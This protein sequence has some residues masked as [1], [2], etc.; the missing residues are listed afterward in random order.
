MTQR[1]LKALCR[2]RDD[3]DIKMINKPPGHLV[4]FLLG[5]PMPEEE[6]GPPSIK[7]LL[8]GS[9]G[10]KEEARTEGCSCIYGNPCTDQYICKNWNDRFEVA[11]A[12]GWDGN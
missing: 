7:E 1:E 9:G 6:K 5:E 4:C 10:K 2:E 11:K 8:E 3:F 12:N